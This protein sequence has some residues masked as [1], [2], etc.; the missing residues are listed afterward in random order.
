MKGVNLV[1]AIFWLLLALVTLLLS[2]VEPGL[3][4]LWFAGSDLHVGAIALV[5]CVYNLARWL[6]TRT[7]AQRKRP[8]EEPAHR[9]RPR[10]LAEDAAPNPAFD[11]GERPP[12]AGEGMGR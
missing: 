3:P 9:H 8:R 12:T 7:A 10:R 1:M 2:W 6:S 5:F 4:L 11:F